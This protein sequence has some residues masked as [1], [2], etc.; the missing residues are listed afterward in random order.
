MAYFTPKRYEKEVSKDPINWQL[1]QINTKFTL[2][3]RVLPLALPTVAILLLVTQVVFP[4]VSFTTQDTTSK[5]AAQSALGYATGFSNFEFSELGGANVLG[6]S[7]YLNE[8]ETVPEFFYI[9]IPKLDIEKAAIET[10]AKTLS[11]DEAL[12]HYKGSALPGEVGNSFI[13]GHSVLPWFYNPKNYKTIFSTLDE[14]EIGDEFF[15]EYQGRKLNYIVEGKRELKPELVNPLEAIKPAYLNESTMVLMTCSPPGTK[16]KR[17][18]I[19][20][21]LVK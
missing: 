11:P 2:R 9:T 14:L 1:N 17:L 10:N 20:A 8:Y 13:Y 15:I 3:S 7:T 18:M 5:P 4:L 16:L 12:G 6:T 21:K 19:D